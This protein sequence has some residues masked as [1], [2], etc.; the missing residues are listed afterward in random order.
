MER[1]L[2]EDLCLAPVLVRSGHD[3]IDDARYNFWHDGQAHYGH[4]LLVGNHG[5]YWKV[6]I[7][8][9][10]EDDVVSLFGDVAFPISYSGVPVC[11][12]RPNPDIRLRFDDDVPIVRQT[13][14]G[15]AFVGRVIPPPNWAESTLYRAA[16]SAGACYCNSQGDLLVRVRTWVVEHVDGGRF[17]PRDFT[18]RAQLLVRL[19]EKIKRVWQDVIGRND[20]LGIHIVRPAPFAD[21]D[22]TRH[23]PILAEANRSPF[24]SSRNFCS[25][26]GWAGVVC[27]LGTYS[28]FCG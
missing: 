13:P 5:Q 9:P 6:S 16:S 28:L 4:E 18:L 7:A 11:Q 3:L 20:H 22:G 17:A 14:Q 26:R 10:Q 15:P 12:F 8:L 2:L 27:L 21:A 25:W 19:R 23:L 24:R 1:T